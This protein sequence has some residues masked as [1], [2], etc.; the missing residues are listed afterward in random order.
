[1][2]DA[3]KRGL[4][5]L[6]IHTCMFSPKERKTLNLIQYFGCSF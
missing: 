2:Y 4:C 1:M 5:A 6:Q 3:T